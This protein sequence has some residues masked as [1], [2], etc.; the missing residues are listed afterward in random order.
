MRFD[1][2]TEKS[3]SRV[4]GSSSSPG[5]LRLEIV[6]SDSSSATNGSSVA[7]V[8]G[9]KRLPANPC[10]EA[11][12]V[13]TR[14]LHIAASARKAARFG[15]FGKTARI[16]RVRETGDSDSPPEIDG[17]LRVFMSVLHCCSRSNLDGI[18]LGSEEAAHRLGCSCAGAATAAMSSTHTDTSTDP[19]FSNARTSGNRSPIL[20]GCFS[21]VSMA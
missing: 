1:T 15:R 18:W 11:G 19:A 17:G 9:K 3:V 16:A 21:S 13:T 14:P 20:S 6:G 10:P 12:A 7:S 8:A 5:N 4:A 2:S